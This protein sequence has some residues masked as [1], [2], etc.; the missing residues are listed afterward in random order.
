MEARISYVRQKALVALECFAGRSA[1]AQD[2]FTATDRGTLEELQQ[3]QDARVAHFAGRVLER[4]AHHTNDCLTV[5]QADALPSQSGALHGFS[6]ECTIC[7]EAIKESDVVV[8]LRCGH[9]FHA[10]CIRRWSCIQASCA[11]CRT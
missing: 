11:T 10:S 6:T 4:L 1:Q 9:N 3:M 8:T 2:A 7:I 5:Q